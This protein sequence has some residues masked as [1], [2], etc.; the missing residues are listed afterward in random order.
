[1][2]ENYESKLSEVYRGLENGDIGIE[3]A[4]QRSNA[5]TAEAATSKAS[6]QA[7]ENI[8]TILQERDSKAVQDKFLKDHPDFVQLKDSGAFESIKQEAGG[9]HDDFSAYFA[10]KVEHPMGVEEVKSPGAEDE[11]TGKPQAPLSE[12]ETEASML[13][14]M[15]KAGEG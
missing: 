6:E 9:M 1:M 8:Q 15:E 7:K 10:Y 5:L 13:K 2:T 3:E 4:M 14:A 12:G 11:Q